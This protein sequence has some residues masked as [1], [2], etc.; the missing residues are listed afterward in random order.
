[1]NLCGK[2]FQNISSSQLTELLSKLVFQQLI[3]SN[4]NERIAALSPE[5]KTLLELRLAQKGLK[6]SIIQARI[7]PE[8]NRDSGVLSYAQERLWI[9]HQ[10]QPELPSYNEIN[11]FQLRGSLNTEALEKS[12]NQI[13]KRHEVLCSKF[14][15]VDGQPVQAI[16]PNLS[17]TLPIVKIEQ[18]SPTE[19]LNLA[20]QEA[21]LPFS[22]SE[23]PLF[24]V[25]LFQLASDQY[26]LLIVVHHIVCDG[27]SVG[28]FMQEVVA[29]YA[30]HSEGK[31]TSLLE[32]SIQYADY[33]LWER[34]RL[35][36]NLFETQLAYWKKQLKG[37]LP[38]L[39]IPTTRSQRTKVSSGKG[40]IK[41]LLLP[42]KLTQQLKAIAQQEDATLFMT[43]LAAFKVLL[44]HYTDLEDILVGSPV[45]NRSRQ[46]FEGL[47]GVFLNTLVL[48]SDLSGNPTFRDLLKRVRE[49]ALAAYTHQDIP[50]EKLVAELQPTRSISQSPLFQVMF[51][52]HNLPVSEFKL[53]GLTMEPLKIDSGVALFDLTLEIRET[54]QGLNA[55]FEYNV[56][57][58]EA[59][60]INRMLEQYQTLLEDI[61]ANPNLHLSQ[62]NLLQEA[63]KQRLLVEFNN[64]SQN[65]PVTQT[66]EQLFAA[67]VAKTPFKIAIVDGQTQLSYQELNI[68][69]NQIARL[70]Q[71]SGLQTGE[72]IGILQ[73]RSIN[74]AIAILGV[75]KA[76]GVYVPID[77]SY[78][79][80]RV[81]YMISHSKIKVLLTDSLCL[82]S[83]ASTLENCFHLQRLICL[84]NLA[85]SL[86]IKN[87]KYTGIESSQ[88][89][90]SPHL[91]TDHL[92]VNTCGIDPAYMIYTSGSTGLPKGAI[93][94]HGGAINHIYAQ[95]DALE[96]TEDFTFLQSA[97][98]SSDIS[99]WQFLAPLLIGGKTVIVSKEI[100]CQPEQLLRVIQQEK[101]T[102][103]ELVPIILSSLIDYISSLPNQ[104][105]SLGHLQYMM[106]TGE[107]VSVELVNRWLELY[108][109]TPIVNAYG[110]TEAAD[111]ITQF[112]IDR[113]LAE[114]QLTVPIGKPLANLN[115]YILDHNLQL[116]PIGVPGEI[117]VSGFGIG[118][119]Y[120][121]DAEKTNLSFVPNPFPDTAKPLPGI[122]SDLIYKTGDLGRW[123][124]D[125]NIEFLGRMDHQVKI[126]GFRIELEEIE[127]VLNRHPAVQKSVVVLREDIPNEQ[128]LVSYVVIDDQVPC[129]HHHLQNF[130]KKQLPNY[131]MPSAFVT[132]KALPLTTNGKV[133]R[134]AL[135]PPDKYL[136]HLEAT[137][138]AARTPI[139]E[140][141][142]GIWRQVLGLEQVGIHDNFFE[143]GG[144]SL[145]ATQLIYQV[146]T[147]FKIELSL[148]C[149]FESPTV[150]EFAEQITKAINLGQE[151]NDLPI[152]AVA[153]DA[154]LP[155]SFGQQ[156]LWIIDRLE[157]NSIAYNDSSLVLI[158]GKLNLAALEQSINEVIHR[159]EILRTSFAVIGEQPVQK[160]ASVVEVS[161]TLVELQ[162]LPESE[163]Q[164][165]VKR[166]EQESIQQPF[167]LTQ[168]PLLRLTLL[169]LDTEQYILI[170]TVHHII[171]D[172]WSAKIFIEEI[173][174]LYEAFVKGKSSPL[175]P[176]T[177]QYV[178]YAVWQRQW[179][180]GK[181]LNTQ[182]SYW[183]RQLKGANTNLK[184][185]VDRASSASPQVENSLGAKCAFT[186]SS[187]V[188]H[189]LKKLSQQE[190][191]T[192]FMTLLT[193][194]NLLLYCYTDQSDIS[195][196]SPITNRDRRKITNLI[197]FFINTIVLR[198]DLSNNPSFLELLSRVKEVALAA[199]SHQDLPFE[200]LVAELQSDRDRSPLFQVWF[201]LQ[202]VLQSER[203]LSGLNLRFLEPE[204]V[205]VRH[206]L[207]LELTETAS[208]I[209][210]LFEY[211]TNLFYA[212]TIERMATTFKMLLDIVVQ[213]PEHS[214]SQFKKL[215]EQA[216]NEQ[217]KL[218][219]NNLKQKY[220]QQL[221]KIK[222]KVITGKIS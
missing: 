45:A 128:R 38:I 217:D 202:N 29:L 83:F 166:Y 54:A 190:G 214:L 159:H 89:L 75:L 146:K 17:I 62:I 176:L 208:E 189:E 171:S 13:L 213:Q 16:A 112:I 125:G 105:R 207:K 173:S 152:L 135:P 154:E 43:L 26:L 98:A 183:Q 120:W 188:A 182:L 57:R 117:C 127:A 109:S 172:A 201:V 18:L 192:L 44:H 35:S 194:F 158:E 85:Q 97:P 67:Q 73:E 10:L 50:F 86:T 181:R 63:E 6:K 58:F 65:Y 7:H 164:A 56:E 160:I 4:V 153:R 41:S 195:I 174:T 108:P 115:L 175:P 103:V 70:L 142:T 1:M 88:E 178:D 180:Q 24:R 21:Q 15:T 129:S 93:I 141:L 99:V 165:E 80:E 137:F 136:S 77:H 177:V 25:K 123:L 126:R 91:S 104:Q 81:A 72:F 198:N 114:D 37:S 53:P 64:N 218:E 30:A 51:I 71:N 116:V 40:A 68:K 107:S 162:S 9:L 95:F 55:S 46:E 169:Q 140:I 168:T 131:M 66:I 197:G 102:L 203:K 78:P 200:K 179:L 111:D 76:G 184:L 147:K 119:G 187:E 122:D 20:T 32:L 139:E 156:R 170:F 96:L 87:G 118:M 60:Q 193:A 209:Q 163:R 48:R 11:L 220:N 222:R 82:K 28:I 23:S 124:P 132:I 2:S 106:V 204:I 143:L 100:V 36:E 211:R 3:M 19:A 210:G 59:N 150:T 5:Q 216:Q 74:F 221:G 12:F 79:S 206:D 8:Q 157:P 49:V 84:D 191:V 34:Q 33:A 42:C 186:I 219:N 31:S 145:L 148:R 130:L 151:L 149:L 205:T 92:A 212:S 61:V 90:A 138:V 69:A 215:L 121:Q 47:I 27:W 22:L 133:D 39:E 196:G 52:L 101:L 94:T 14:V 185:P 134:R 161:L 167:E 110:P 155:L 144:H 199:Y 113:P